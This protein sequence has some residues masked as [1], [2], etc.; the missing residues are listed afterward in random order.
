MQRQ[1]VSMNKLQKG[2]V[3]IVAP[4]D[5]EARIEE[6]EEE[7]ETR[8]WTADE[9]RRALQRT[10]DS[11]ELQPHELLQSFDKDGSGQLSKREVALRLELTPPRASTA[12]THVP[13]SHPLDFDSHRC[14]T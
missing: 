8:E 11:L 7:E 13:V 3:R 4:S 6:E 10:L 14:S 2:K 9:L 5:R 12:S 1:Q